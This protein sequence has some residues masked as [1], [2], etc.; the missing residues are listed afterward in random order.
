MVFLGS[1]NRERVFRFADSSSA[2]LAEGKLKAAPRGREA[3]R[4]LH[5]ERQIFQLCLHAIEIAAH[6]FQAGDGV[7]SV[8]ER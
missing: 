1:E 8:L 3:P 4:Q 7:T 2:E 5:D 6:L